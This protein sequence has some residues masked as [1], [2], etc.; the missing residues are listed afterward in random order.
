MD[1]VGEVVRLGVANRY[2]EVTGQI[3]GAVIQSDRVQEY[4]KEAG[5][6]GRRAIHS[7]KDKIVD[8]AR[9]STSTRLDEQKKA[10]EEHIQ[11]KRGLNQPEKDNL[12]DMDD[13]ED[14][15]G[16]EDVDQPDA[17]GASNTNTN[18]GG[19]SGTG[20]GMQDQ[21]GLT[22]RADLWDIPRH[23]PDTHVAYL[24]IDGLSGVV[25]FETKGEDI[26]YVFTGL[27]DNKPIL[28]EYT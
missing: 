27:L 6:T 1:L 20:V 24:K 23:V 26:H 18:T 7:C 14:S 3:A 5:K 2:G 9:G 21:R 28:Y 17:G 15:V 25:D 12:K 4:V 8:I 11:R 22:N 13:Y 16:E 19:P 10:R